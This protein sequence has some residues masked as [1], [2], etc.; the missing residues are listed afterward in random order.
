MYCSEDEVLAL[1]KILDTPKASGPDGVHLHAQIYGYQCCT[2]S[3]KV[4]QCIHIYMQWPLPSL[5]HYHK[6]LSIPSLIQW[7]M[8]IP[9]CAWLDAVFKPGQSKCEVMY[10]IVPSIALV[11]GSVFHLW[12]SNIGYIISLVFHTSTVMMLGTWWTRRTWGWGTIFTTAAA[13]Y[14][15]KEKLKLQM[16]HCYEW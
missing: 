13:T 8:A 15:T 14:A 1:I 7:K 6:F 10:F 3:H 5:M 4:F 2:L 11:W 16:K 12:I 9:I